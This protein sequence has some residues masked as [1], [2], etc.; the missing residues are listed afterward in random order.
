MEMPT[1]TSAGSF[2]STASAASVF[3]SSTAS[4]VVSAVVSAC[5]SGAAVSA[6]L[7]LQAVMENTIAAA[8]PAA[9]NF[10]SDLIILV[11]PLI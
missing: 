11:P 9:M 8:S 2:P 6:G 1:F 5:G 3:A 7:E 4:A 10:L